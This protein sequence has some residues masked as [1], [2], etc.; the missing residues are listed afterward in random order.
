MDAPMEINNPLIVAQVTAEFARYEAALVGNDVATLDALFWASPHTL[1]YGVGENL[2]G[3]DAI[4]A[5]RAAR[6][7]SGLAREIL[8]TQITT[9]GDDFATTHIEFQRLGA[10]RPG[11]QSQTWMRTPD[12]WRVVCAHVSLLG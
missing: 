1:R 4:K 3:F 7:A 6:P 8:R 10:S 11:R 2:Y 5:F 9:Y 12:G